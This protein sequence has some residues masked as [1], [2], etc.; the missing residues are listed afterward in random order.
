M[1]E[2]YMLL[3]ADV[4]EALRLMPDNSADACLADVPYGLGPR[5]PTPE[6]LAAYILGTTSLNTG[7]D[8]MGAKWKIPSVA[9]WK[10]LLRVLKPGAPVLSFAGSR[11]Q[12]LIAIGMRAGGFEIQDS[13]VAVMWC[14]GEGMPKPSMP[15]DKFI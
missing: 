8:F 7:G 6:E 3:E 15:T 10:E 2:R 14:F 4:L 11:T 12:D 1:T 5:E 9:V 13:L